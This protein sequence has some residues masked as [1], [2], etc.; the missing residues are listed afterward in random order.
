MSSLNCPLWNQRQDRWFPEPVR[1]PGVPAAA[2]SWHAVVLDDAQ[3]IKFHELVL[4]TARLR[5]GGVPALLVV[6]GKLD[7]AR[8]KIQAG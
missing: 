5:D 4:V 6:G 8:P 2:T 3:A 7:Q 1:S